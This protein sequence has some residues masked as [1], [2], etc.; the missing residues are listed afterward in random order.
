MGETIDCKFFGQENGLC[1]SLQILCPGRAK[2]VLRK[3]FLRLEE[4]I[5]RKFFGKGSAAK[6]FEKHAKSIPNPT[7]NHPKTCPEAPSSTKEP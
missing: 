1:E 4:T 7:E 5:D 6:R 3:A 2:N